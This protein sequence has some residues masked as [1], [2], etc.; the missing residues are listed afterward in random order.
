MWIKVK[1]KILSD[2]LAKTN[3][4]S[5]HSGGYASQMF[6]NV[7]IDALPTT[8]LIDITTVSP[9]C[10]VRQRLAE[11]EVERPGSI[12]ISRDK[13]LQLAREAGSETIDIRDAGSQVQISVAG[14][15]FRLH[16][17]EGEL[18]EIQAV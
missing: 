18:P 7:K 5:V 15:T 17:L 8:A 2:T 14:T 4:A 1:G 16:K 3:P 12:L 13:L 10:Q 9:A 11:G 6:Q